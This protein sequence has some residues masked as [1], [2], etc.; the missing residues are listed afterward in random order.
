MKRLEATIYGRVQ[1]VYFRETTRQVAQK[2]QLTGWTANQSDGSVQVV[3]E[4]QETALL[5]LVDFLH[6]GPPMAQVDRVEAVWAEPTR[7]FTQFVVKWI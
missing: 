1:G 6:K 4:G 2:L 5:Q 7:E 3:A